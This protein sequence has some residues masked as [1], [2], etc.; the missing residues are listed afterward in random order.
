M[1]LHPITCAI[2]ALAESHAATADLSAALVAAVAAVDNETAAAAMAQAV[3][4]FHG[5]ELTQPRQRGAGFKIEPKA[6][7]RE[8]AAYNALQAARMFLRRERSV[9]FRYTIG[10]DGHC[11]Y[12][13]VTLEPAGERE[14]DPIEA[15]A[16]L[17]GKYGDK[18]E[19]Q[20]AIKA[21]AGAL[22]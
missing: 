10:T 9:D 1:N 16:R 12:E 19:F 18:P 17:V 13:L 5:L 20:A 6:G 2:L 14:P 7:P 15:L 3:E 22:K 11:A 4:E 8:Q 21:A